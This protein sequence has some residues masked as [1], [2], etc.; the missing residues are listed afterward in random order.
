MASAS[1]AS[2]LSTDLWALVIGPKY[3]TRIDDRIRVSVVQAGK[4]WWACLRSQSIDSANRSI[5]MCERM[6]RYAYRHNAV[7][8]S[9]TKHQAPSTKICLNSVLLRIRDFPSRTGSFGL[10]AFPRGGALTSEEHLL[11]LERNFVCSGPTSR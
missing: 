7:P 2:P 1:W 3:E 11:D 5:P 10:L 6:S 8:S 4:Q 9:C